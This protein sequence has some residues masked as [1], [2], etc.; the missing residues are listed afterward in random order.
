M[1]LDQASNDWAILI[2]Y[3]IIYSQVKLA[4]ANLISLIPFLSFLL[5]LFICLMV[6]KNIK[7]ETTNLVYSP[8][9]PGFSPT[10]S[11]LVFPFNF[12]SNKILWM[13]R[14]GKEDDHKGKEGFILI[15]SLK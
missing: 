5:S 11:L 7:H 6:E 9:P 12:F 10:L 4:C 15:L 14:L 2:G 1:F 8:P 3:F 13:V